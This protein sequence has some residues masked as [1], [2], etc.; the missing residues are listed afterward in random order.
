MDLMYNMILSGGKIMRQMIGSE[1]KI[2][3]EEGEIT[4]VLGVM[5][6]V[7]FFNVRRGRT[8][9]DIDDIDKY[10]VKGKNIENGMC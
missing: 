7:T 8:I 10:L 4:N 2:G 9:I 1:V 6:E 3:D 5:Y